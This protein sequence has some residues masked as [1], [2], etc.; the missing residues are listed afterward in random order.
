MA[1]HAHIR[2]DTR[3]R[4]SV[5]GIGHTSVAVRLAGRGASGGTTRPR[6]VRP[7]PSGAVHGDRWWGLFE[8]EPLAEE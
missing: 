2:E 7:T 5:E 8:Q 6:L 3:F 1:P 4:A